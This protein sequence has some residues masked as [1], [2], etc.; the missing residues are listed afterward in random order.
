MQCHNHFNSVSW[1]C[2]DG[3]TDIDGPSSNFCC[4]CCFN[5]RVNSRLSLLE[6]SF[7]I[8]IF[9]FSTIY[10]IF[11]EILLSYAILTIPPIKDLLPRRLSATRT[12]AIPHAKRFACYH[13]LF[14]GRSFNNRLIFQFKIKIPGLSR[15]VN[16]LIVAFRKNKTR[17]GLFPPTYGLNSKVDWVSTSLGEEQQ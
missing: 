17:I 2:A 15:C 5:F 10:F 1:T 4:I 7:F 14:M 13:K 3:K 16:F 12:M 9:H 8:F 6:Y 11:L